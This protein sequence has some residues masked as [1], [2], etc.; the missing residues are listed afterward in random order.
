MSARR[1]VLVRTTLDGSPRDFRVRL[2]QLADAVADM[3]SLM[4]LTGTDPLPADLR[5]ATYAH[6]AAQV[7][8]R[9]VTQHRPG[10]RADHLVVHA[11]GARHFVVTTAGFRAARLTFGVL[12]IPAASQR[13]IVRAVADAARRSA[14]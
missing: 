12:A 6:A 3:R 8:A 11:D 10:A 1:T 9:T 2:D 7:I 4:G 14:A 13:D 5:V